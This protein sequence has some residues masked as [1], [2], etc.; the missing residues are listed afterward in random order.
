MIS[1][2]FAH[3]ISYAYSSYR[4]LWQKYYY[5]IEFYTSLFNNSDLSLLFLHGKSNVFDLD[6]VLL[7]DIYLPTHLREIG[8]LDCFDFQNNNQKIQDRQKIS[9]SNTNDQKEYLN[10]R[11]KTICTET[12]SKWRLM[13]DQNQNLMKDRQTIVRFLWPTHRLEDLGC[14]NRFWMGTANQSRFSMLRI[15]TFT[16]V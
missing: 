5:T 10:K 11:E 6:F 4:Q 15:H 8:I 16:N 2:N 12:I 13:L 3:S 9:H 14:I 7:E 1:F